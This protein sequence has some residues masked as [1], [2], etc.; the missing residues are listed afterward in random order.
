[1][2]P[3]LKLFTL[4]ACIV[5]VSCR[6]PEMTKIHTINIPEALD[7]IGPINLSEIAKSIKYIPLE[8]KEESFIGSNPQI[9]YDDNYIVV[10]DHTGIIKVFDNDGKFIRSINRIGRGPEEYTPSFSEYSLINGNIVISNRNQIIEYD[11]SGNFIRRVATPTVD[12]YSAIL[13]IMLGENRYIS[14]LYNTSYEE[15]EYC[16]VIYDTLSDITK[17]V[18]IRAIPGRA[19]PGA[20]LRSTNSSGETV[21][22]F[23]IMLY[24]LFQYGETCRLFFPDSKE[25]YFVD[26]S[27]VL[28]TAFVIEYG[29]YRVPNG[30]YTESSDDSRHISISDFIES[31]D[32]LFARV[33]TRATI[34][35]TKYS[36]LIYDKQTKKSSILYNS[37]E[38]KTGL[39]DDIANGPE[40]WPS[41]VSGKKTLISQISALSFI[42]F[43]ENN[44]LP[45]ELEKVTSV[46]NEDSNPIAVIVELK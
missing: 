28:D 31:E 40:F 34:S 12:E 23:R 4:C 38:N 1:M 19:V 44:T 42:E 7:N 11:I 30:D 36:H 46:I 20:Q 24:T 45:K 43:S 22:F 9:L 27:N 18:A 16:A 2:N 10:A 6:S 37:S 25:I 35:G 14:P 32:L 15:K 39:K 26:K 8:T 17:M 29:A 5:A 21:T 3:A 33:D 13:P 41:K